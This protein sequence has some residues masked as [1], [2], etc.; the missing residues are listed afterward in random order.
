MMQKYLPVPSSRYTQT[1][2]SRA[3]EYHLGELAEVA[4]ANREV[5]RLVYDELVTLA[6]TGA[7]SMANYVRSSDNL[8]WDMA[9][10]GHRSPVFHDFMDKLEQITG[11]SILMITATGHKGM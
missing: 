10:A 8:R 7:V 6:A 1:S 9:E 5:A 4:A 11:E 3:V 2:L